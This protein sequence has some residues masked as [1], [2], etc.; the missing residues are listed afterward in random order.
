MEENNE[1]YNLKDEEILTVGKYQGFD[2]TTEKLKEIYDNFNALKSEIKPTL[3]LGHGEQE[4][5]KR[6]GYPSAGFIADLKLSDDGT[7]LYADFMNVPKQVKELIDK[8][9]YSRKS[10]EVIS[11]YKDDN[12]NKRYGTVL[13]GLALLGEEMPEIKTLSDIQKLYYSDNNEVTLITLSNKEESK[14]PDLS[15]AEEANNN[16][17]AAKPAE[18]PTVVEQVEPEKPAENTV[19]TDVVVETIDSTVGQ[20]EKIIEMLYNFLE[21]SVD[22]DE[23]MLSRAEKSV[24]K[25]AD[26]LKKKKKKEAPVELAEPVKAEEAPKENPEVMAKLSDMENKMKAMSIELEK[27]NQ[28]A[29]DAEI[30]KVNLSDSNYIESLVKEGKVLPA[31]TEKLKEL[32]FSMNKTEN[33]V[34]MLSDKK[35]VNIKDSIKEFIN[36]LPNQINLSA[37][38]TTDT[39]I[40]EEKKPEEIKINQVKEQ[41]PQYFKK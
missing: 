23:I 40:N 29:K 39:V 12:K 34:I 13:C 21:G 8:K 5:L 28:K 15:K 11:N 27:A 19:P 10:A 9:A 33:M 26:G 31:Q 17:P 37:A 1:T 3:K 2:F 4:I 35:Q 14:M 38:L 24:M 16:L 41:F 25:L 18:N 6:T 32:F 22:T 20:L 30:E 36:A 7:K